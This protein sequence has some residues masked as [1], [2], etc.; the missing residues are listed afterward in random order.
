MKSNPSVS[1]DEQTDVVIVGYGGS[2]ALAALAAHDAGAKVT[3]VE[4]SPHPGGSTVLAGGSVKIALDV[5]AAVSYL[6]TTQGGRC[7]E[8]LV[9]TM[10]QGMYEI[11]QY[12]EELAKVNGAKLN[13]RKD[14]ERV[15]VDSYLFPGWDSLGFIA[16][17]QIPGFNGFP[18]VR[19]SAPAGQRL[20]KLLSDNVDFRKIEVRF[21]TAVKQLVRDGQ[22]RIIGVRA[23]QEGR[24]VS[25]NARKAVVLASGGFEFNEKLKAESFEA[26]P[27][28]SMGHLPNTGDGILM[29]Q[30]VGAA[31]WHMWHLHGSYGFKFPEY[32]VAFRTSLSG[33]RIQTR[34]IGWINVDRFGK[35]FMNEY[36]RAPQDTMH[37]PLQLFDPDLPGF[38]RIPCY[39]VFGEEGRRLGPIARP[40]TTQMEQVHQWSEDNSQEVERGWIISSM[41]IKGLADK[42]GV[43]AANLIQTIKGWNKICHKGEDPDFRRP[44]GTMM[45]IETRPY[46]AMQA[47]PIC[48]NTLGGPV[49]DVKQRVLDPYGNPIPRLYA[50]GELGSFYGHVYL[51][52][53]NLAE[54]FVGGRIAGQA[55][56]E[57]K[58]L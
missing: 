43:D 56:A 5:E 6:A 42:I 28:Y 22:G 23:E 31:L 17:T 36:E 40:I 14:K 55:A 29:S 54:C 25:I 47:W 4:K 39:L 12:M 24:S 19:G 8:D 58:P 26:Y 11:P 32:P 53:G 9:R 35:R 38:P 50:V 21:S 3:I 33:P 27:V 41:T 46:Y 45:P 13:I 10:A 2:G 51:L 57:E 48:T 30:K 7:S 18:W 34:K 1:W 16:I 49:H 52:G 15:G 20:V 44:P 37:R